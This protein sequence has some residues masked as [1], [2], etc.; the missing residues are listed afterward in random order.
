MSNIFDYMN[1]RDIDIKKVEFNEIDNLILARVSYFPL[2]GLIK[3]AGAKL[4]E[5][6]INLKN[7]EDLNIYLQKEDKDFFKILAQSTRFGDLIMS[8]YENHID[9]EKEKQF[10]AVTILL[11]YDVLYVSFRGTDNTI[12]G[13]KE[14]FNMSFQDLVPSQI[15]AVTYLEKIAEK[16]PK[17]QIIVGGHSKGGNLAVYAA[18]FCNSKCKNRIIDVYN[19]DGPGFQ[20][21][22]IKSIEY[23]EIL[24]KIHTYRPQTSIIGKLLNHEE[25]YITLKSTETGIMQHDLYSW[26]VLGD[27]FI[28]TESTNASDVID[29]TITEWLKEVKPEQREKFIDILFEIL[30]KTDADTLHEM[31][32]NWLNS[33]MTILKG[34]KDINEQ[35]K[36]IVSKSLTA[37]V[38][39]AKGNIKINPPKGLKFRRKKDL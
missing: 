20:E 11:P 35:D 17:R 33:S 31:K 5:A 15:E 4:K 29:K 39:A 23:K 32:D 18:A 8:N 19:N 38:S 22:V 13:W 37:L 36:E 28:R 9:K 27:K 34:Y 2:D 12:V 1:W 10:A 14:D 16:Y 25:K 30:N 26:Q 3:E 24:N 21:N 6:Y 7:K